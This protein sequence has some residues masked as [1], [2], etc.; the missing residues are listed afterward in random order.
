VK[1]HEYQAKRLLT[2]HGVAVPLGDLATTAV[3]ARAVAARLKP[4]FAIKAQVLV[5]GRGKAGGIRFGRTV[6][7]AAEAAEQILGSKVRG[8]PVRS[9]LIEEAAQVLR[10][11]YLSVSVDRV[12][13]CPLFVV[14]R[15]G[16][17]DI[18]ETA[19]T[20]PDTIAKLRIDPCVGLRSFHVHTLWGASGLGSEDRDSW[21]GVVRALYAAFR[22]NDAT[23]AEINP[24]VLDTSRRLV[25]VD[26][27][28]V[29]D[30]NGLFRHTELSQLRD[31]DH[32]TE[33]ERLARLAGVT[34]VELD[35]DIGCL[36]NGAGLAMATMDSVQRL[37]GNPANFLDIGGGAKHDTVA[38][39]MRIIL[40]SA[41]VRVVLV[42]VLGGI[43]RCDEV[44]SGIVA[45]VGDAGVDTALVVRLSGTNEAQGRRVLTHSGLHI[46]PAEDLAQAAA[47]A[48]AAA[49]AASVG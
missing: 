46:E 27:K 7:E 42:N 9:V 30:D 6:G 13:A 8:L 34:Y 21:A 35:G 48:V 43:T 23:L 47:K 37:G 16:G 20:Q 3:G 24:L 15:H 28:M 29:I 11:I 1:I 25:A 10:E 45:G 2:E 31:L 4:P 39:A 5:G 14:S 12:A 33:R 17:V 32:E 41:D 44:A 36:V 40:S 22:S 38:E 18:E 49:R 19:R 26:A